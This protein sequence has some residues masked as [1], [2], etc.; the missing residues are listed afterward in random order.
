MV[1]VTSKKCIYENCKTIPN[2][3]FVGNKTAIY[4]NIHKLENMVDVKHIK[5]IHIDCCKRPHLITSG[6]IKVSIVKTIN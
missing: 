4:C 1:N 2:Y 6:K 5:C 3:N